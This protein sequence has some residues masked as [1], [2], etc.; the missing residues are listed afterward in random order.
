[1]QHDK[2][3]ILHIEIV[4]SKVRFLVSDGMHLI[5]RGS[6]SEIRKLS[7]DLVL[8]LVMIQAMK[9]TRLMF[10]PIVKTVENTYGT[11]AAD[12]SS[13]T[14]KEFLRHIKEFVGSP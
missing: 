8:N 3:K 4:I 6:M 12:A 14:L 7:S 1:M 2:H 11:D 5:K 9:E 10:L 13:S